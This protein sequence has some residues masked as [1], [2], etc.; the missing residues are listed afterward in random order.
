MGYQSGG[1]CCPPLP[2]LQSNVQNPGC[3]LHAAVNTAHPVLHPHCIV[4]EPH[5]RQCESAAGFR[6]FPREAQ[7]PARSGQ[8][9]EESYQQN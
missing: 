3:G 6:A 7:Q 9:P 8:L 2:N 4:R 1:V 5:T